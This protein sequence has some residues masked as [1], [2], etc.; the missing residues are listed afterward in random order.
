MRPPTEISGGK[1]ARPK[2]SLGFGSSQPRFGKKV[3]GGKSG[4]KFADRME[5]E[6]AKIEADKLRVVNMNL[7]VFYDAIKADLERPDEEVFN[8]SIGSRFL[9]KDAKMNNK[10]HSLM[11]FIHRKLSS[12]DTTFISKVEFKILVQTFCRLSDSQCNDI[13]NSLTKPKVDPK[14]VIKSKD[15]INGDLRKENNS[16]N[17]RLV[18]TNARGSSKNRRKNGINVNVMIRNEFGDH[19]GTGGRQRLNS[20]ISPSK[21]SP[22]DNV[23]LDLAVL[24]NKFESF[25]KS[26][27]S[28]ASI[29]N[30][31]LIRQRFADF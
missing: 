10:S 3:A 17:S 30:V 16:P 11:R 31:K 27:E 6:R 26:Q 25:C 20:S 28:M 8:E 21:D 2:S 4:A 1:K 9:V 24:Q 23:K 13:F 29:L 22:R 12:F 19:S 7:K 18:G 5:G 15:N 14:S